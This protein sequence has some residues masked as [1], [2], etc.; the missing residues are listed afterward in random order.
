[1][2]TGLWSFTSA[3]DIQADFKIVNTLLDAG[4]LLDVAV[5]SA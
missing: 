5:T 3:V 1:M 2:L 4:E